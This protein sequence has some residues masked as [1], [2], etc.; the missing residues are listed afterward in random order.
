MYCRII[1]FIIINFL[2][3]NIIYLQK[4][5][6]LHQIRFIIVMEIFYVYRKVWWFFFIY[7]NNYQNFNIL[8]SLVQWYFIKCSF[9]AFFCC[10]FSFKWYT[11]SLHQYM[12]DNLL[13]HIF[14]PI[15]KLIFICYKV[16]KKSNISIF[17]FF[18]L[19]IYLLL[20]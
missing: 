1:I 9:Y 8:T 3:L 17:L 14:T 13:I 20:Q 5:I 15:L 6:Y 12:F 18:W 10:F 4:C 2:I 7:F 19:I 11:K 16:T